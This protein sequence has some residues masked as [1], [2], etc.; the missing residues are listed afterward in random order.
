VDQVAAQRP[1]SGERAILISCGETA[2]SNNSAAR[3]AVILRFSLI[4][5]AL[6]AR[7]SSTNGKHRSGLA[8]FDAIQE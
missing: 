5:P 1:Q 3:I 2:E 4:P 6:V 7:E 8:M